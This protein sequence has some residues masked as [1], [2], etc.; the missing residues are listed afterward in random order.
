VS[1]WLEVLATGPLATIQDLGRPG[2][3]HWGVSRS[4]AAD[5]TS[6]R[7]AN[8]L[9]GNPEDAASIEVTAGGLQVRAVDAGLVVCL[10]GAPCPASLAGRSV[11]AGV[12][13]AL[14]AGEE[15]HLAAPTRGLRTYLGVGGGIDVPPVLG[16]RST[17]LLGHLGPATLSPGDLLP[18]GDAHAEYPPVDRAPAREP[19]GD[20]V[21]LRVR[22]GPRD[23]WFTAAGCETFLSARWTAGPD[24]SRIGVRLSGPAL[25]R[26]HD[27]ELASEGVIRGAV[28]VPPSGSPT[29]F[30]ADHPVT[31]GYPVIATVV[32]ED[33]DLAAQVRPGQPIRFRSVGSPQTGS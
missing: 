13:L 32:A 15:L 8:R 5:R 26:A 17:D 3:A 18:V 6:A 7:L 28:Q 31:G 12:R 25:E 2:Y 16:S 1:G 23:A 14:R 9:V 27:G 29:I 20:V 21:E 11:A 33:V 10:T 19:A 24:S 4:G 22:P 30:L